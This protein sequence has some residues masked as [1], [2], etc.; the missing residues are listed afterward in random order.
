M[1]KL[2]ETTSLISAGKVT[3][4]SVYNPLICHAQR[5]P[6]WKARSLSRV[7]SIS[8]SSEAS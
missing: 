2:D 1:E 4:T 8:G 6:I 5:A 3:G 7:T